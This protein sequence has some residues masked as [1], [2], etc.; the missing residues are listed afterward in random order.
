MYDAIAKEGLE[1]P[2]LAAP[3]QRTMVLQG[4]PNPAIPGKLPEE[5]E[6][7]YES[8][9]PIGD[10][11]GAFGVERKNHIH[12]GVDL[13][14]EEGSTVFA[15]IGGV[16]TNIIEDF[17]GP[18]A[19]MPWWNKT[20]A[21]V[22][23]DEDGVWIYGEITVDPTITIGATVTAGQS[24]GK[25]AQVLIHDKGRPMSMLHLERYT[26]GTTESV[27]IWEKGTPKPDNLLDPTP[28]LIKGLNLEYIEEDTGE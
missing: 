4:N 14:A 22:V 27:G 5:M 17:T 21:V 23:E 18:G 6:L 15:M 11:H 7:E 28:I 20:S 9:I 8:M 10:H 16:V 2:A 13:Y 19:G 24:L 1:P 12:E 26:K 3:L 25:V